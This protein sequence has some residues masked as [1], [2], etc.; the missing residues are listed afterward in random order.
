MQYDDFD[1]REM[2]SVSLRCANH[3]DELSP[4]TQWGGD[5]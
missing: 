3:S 2:F 5:E 4:E 1:G